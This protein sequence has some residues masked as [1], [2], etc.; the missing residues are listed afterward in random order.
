MQSCGKSRALTDTITATIALAFVATATAQ[1]SAPASMPDAGYQVEIVVFRH[2]DQRGNTPEQPAPARMA[3]TSIEPGL[4]LPG[5]PGDAWPPLGA[6]QLQLTGIATRLRQLGAYQLLYHGGWV[7]PL[8]SQRLAVATPLPTAARDAGLSGSVTLF[9]ERFTHAVVDIAL[10][11]AA[12]AADSGTYRQYSLRQGR[13][14]RGSAPQY[15]DDPRFGVILLVRPPAGASE[16]EP[17]D[18][19]EPMTLPES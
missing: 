7:Q 2:L 18:A 4:T 1:E 17:T 12:G 16:S 5:N 9:R 11:E 3:A 14:L 6:G 19:A 13:R 8:L 15:F 10:R